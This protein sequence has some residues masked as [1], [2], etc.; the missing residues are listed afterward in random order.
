MFLVLMEHKVAGDPSRLARWTPGSLQP[1]HFLLVPFFNFIKVHN[2][3]K[4]FLLFSCF[5][6]RPSLTLQQLQKV[7]FSFPLEAFH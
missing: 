6:A 7:T 1:G 4:T 3:L 5:V 2:S